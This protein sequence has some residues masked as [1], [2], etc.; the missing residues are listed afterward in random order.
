[1]TGKLIKLEDRIIYRDDL[2]NTFPSI[3]KKRD[4]ELIVAFRQA[5]NRLNMF[6][7]GMHVDPA[8]RGVY[9]VSRDNGRTWDSKPRHLVDDYCLGISDPCLNVL[10]DGDLLATYFTHQVLLKDDVPELQPH[11]MERLVAGRWV[12]RAGPGYTIR[13]ADGGVSWDEPAAIPAAPVAAYGDRLTEKVSRGHVVEG[14]D[15]SL[16]A[17]MCTRPRQPGRAQLNVTRDKGLT[18]ETVS[19]L[20]DAE[21]TVFYE[22]N[23]FRTVSGKL[24]A[25]LRSVKEGEPKERANPLFTCESYDNGATW[26]N[27]T[28]HPIY[29]PNPFDVTALQSGN[30]LLS[31]GYRHAPYGIR[32]RLLNGECTNIGESEEV[33]LRDDGGGF[34]LG[35]TGAVQ[36]DGGHILIV[37]YFYDNDQGERYIAGTLCRESH[38]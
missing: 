18:W 22:P 37:Y 13:S 8:S 4:G 3:V 36:L 30:V 17:L 32:A 6:P 12:I 2:Y 35:Y 16:L 15:G 10:Q 7:G 26:T 25:F 11:R 33:I 21:R 19:V 1:M 20:P 14:E 9:V 29:T 34:D 5:P 28:E 27:L 31:Y 38:S 24:V 23:L